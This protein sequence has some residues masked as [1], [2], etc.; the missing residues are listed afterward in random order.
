[1][2]LLGYAFASDIDMVIFKVPTSTHPARWVGMEDLSK[3][4][5]ERQHVH[6]RGLFTQTCRRPLSSS[7][8]II[9]IIFKYL[10]IL[11]W[12]GR[13]W[14]CPSQRGDS[15]A[16]PIAKDAKLT[17]AVDR[18]IRTDVNGWGFCLCSVDILFIGSACPSESRGH[19]HPVHNIFNA[20]WIMAWCM[21]ITGSAL[22]H[23]CKTFHTWQ[24]Q[25]FTHAASKSRLV[26][27][28]WVSP[29]ECN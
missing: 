24:A 19:L 8:I 7:D 16:F 9:I 3:P 5:S 27:K 26:L 17:P 1:M 2:C 4:T 13:N 20:R 11:A 22:F 25:V 12:P 6:C 14:V 21:W 15:A 10:F 28:P 18:E 29:F 23:D